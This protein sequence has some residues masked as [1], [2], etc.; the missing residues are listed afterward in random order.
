[1]LGVRALIR[2]A[3][4]GTQLLS[5]QASR[6]REK[7]CLLAIASNEALDAIADLFDF[8]TGVPSSSTVQPLLLAWHRVHAL[9]LR[10]FFRIWTESGASN[11]MQSD[12]ARVSTLVRSQVQITIRGDGST[13]VLDIEREFA[14]ADYRSVRDRLSKELAVE[15]DLLTKAPVRSLRGR[16]YKES[17][18]CVRQ[19]RIRCLQEGAW[20]VNS[21][22]G[23]RSNRPRTWRFYRLAANCASPSGEDTDA[24]RQAPPL[25][26]NDSSHTDSRRTRGSA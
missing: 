12:F 1:M 19:Q 23:Q 6:P 13:S 24:R 16:L 18:D 3:R 2:S 21:S 22:P 8:Q 4:T 7:Q 9:A 5:E 14:N 25:D 11:T 15:D 20:F 17:F 10:L 26:R